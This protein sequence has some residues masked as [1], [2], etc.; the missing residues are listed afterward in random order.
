VHVNF[1]DAGPKWLMLAYAELQ[2]AD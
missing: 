1:D 2:P